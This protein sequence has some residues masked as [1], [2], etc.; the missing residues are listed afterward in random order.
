MGAAGQTRWDA[1]VQQKGLQRFGGSTVMWRAIC[2]WVGLLMARH[3]FRRRTVHID[4][5]RLR[6]AGM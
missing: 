2:F 3:L 4:L 1:P 5:E 6:N